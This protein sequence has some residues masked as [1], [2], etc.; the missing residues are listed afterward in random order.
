MNKK[1]GQYFLQDKT[2]LQ[3]IAGVLNAHGGDAIIEIG[4]GHGEL[5]EE[6]IATGAHIIAIEKD[7]TLG[8]DLVKKYDKNVTVVVGDVR[9]ELLRVVRKMEGKEYHVAGNI[10]YYLTGYIFRMLG[11]LDHKPTRAV[12]TTQKE[13]AERIAKTDT[14]GMNILAASVL[15]WA[16][17]L[18]VATVP[19]GMFSP[20]PKVDSAIVLLKAHSIADHAFADEEKY[21]SFMKFVKILF[22]HP[23]KTAVS[24]LSSV[25]AKQEIVRVFEEHR[26]DPK[27]RA[28]KFSFEVLV[29]LSK[30]FSFY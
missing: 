30:Q 25:Y 7:V 6:L 24:N 28:G 20:S 12:F 1:L 10:P 16:D 29:E 8:N 21:E 5:T 4:P 17:A 18:Y 11:E 26:I 9:Q 27:I 3:E 22:A 13:V 2:K 14:V 23:R 19:R 15:W